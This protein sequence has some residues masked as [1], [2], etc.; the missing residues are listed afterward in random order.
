VVCAVSHNTDTCVYGFIEMNID[1][2][3]YMGYKIKLVLGF[4]EL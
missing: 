4:I 2:Y 1:L 3:R